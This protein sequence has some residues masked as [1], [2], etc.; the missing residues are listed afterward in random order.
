MIE[1]RN[2]FQR[3]TV[4]GCAKRLTRSDDEVQPDMMTMQ[5]VVCDTCGLRFGI[6]H[7][8][9]AVDEQLATRQATWLVQQFTWDHIREVKHHQSIPLPAACD[10]EDAHTHSKERHA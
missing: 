6:G 8:L 1:P 4:N 10:I 7:R 9:D 2:A 5:I 3:R